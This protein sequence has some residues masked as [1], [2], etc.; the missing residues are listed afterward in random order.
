MKK[1]YLIIL[2]ILLT[3]CTNYNDIS[4]IA[5]VSSIGISVNGNNYNVYVK[6]LSSNQEN[7]ENI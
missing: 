3:G 2:V 1:I 7:E 6:V 5:V 4:N